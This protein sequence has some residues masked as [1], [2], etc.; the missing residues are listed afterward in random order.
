M[1]ERGNKGAP[2]PVFMYSI[3]INNNLLVDLAK[4]VGHSAKTWLKLSHS[5]SSSPINP[6]MLLSGKR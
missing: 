6:F 5:Y 4:F 2:K 1:Q 3:E